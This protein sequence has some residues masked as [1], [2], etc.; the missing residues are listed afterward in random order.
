M[1]TKNTKNVE[2]KQQLERQREIIMENTKI[3]KI[4]KSASV[5][6]TVLNVIRTI[7]TVCTIIALVCG[8]ICLWAKDKADG[9]II[10]E[11]GNVRIHAPVSE[12]SFVEGNGFE[13][14][15]RLGIDNVM[16]WGALNC[17]VAAGVG[18]LV[19]VLISVIAKVFVELKE[20]DT[21]FTESIQKRLKVTAILTTIMVAMESL[22]FAAVV[23]LSF[24][25]VH[26][27]IGYGIELQKNE[28]E[29]L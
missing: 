15:N 22:G 11:N 27:I 16:I 24:W 8:L 5:T 21:P 20:S 1:K 14:L 12:E 23:A 3:A 28:D 25:C 18:A 6:A 9:T 2:R 26:S 29:T 19:A 4:K 17:F 10:Y 7:L 13:F